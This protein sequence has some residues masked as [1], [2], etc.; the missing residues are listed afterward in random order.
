MINAE[1]MV[2]NCNS[3]EQKENTLEKDGKYAYFCFFH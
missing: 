3:I 1:Q 2:Q